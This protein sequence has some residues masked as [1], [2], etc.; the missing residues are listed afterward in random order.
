MTDLV[1]CDKNS[2]VRKVDGE[3]SRH[4]EHVDEGLDHNIQRRLHVVRLPFRWHLLYE[5]DAQA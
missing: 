2:G 5:K 1:E 4:L 3:V